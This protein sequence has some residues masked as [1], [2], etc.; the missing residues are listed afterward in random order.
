MNKLVT[1]VDPGYQKSVS[2]VTLGARFCVKCLW[3][4]GHVMSLDNTLDEL[5][6]KQ[7]PSGVFG[8]SQAA[9]MVALTTKSTGTRDAG[10]LFPPRITLTKPVNAPAK[11]PVALC[12]VLLQE[13]NYIVIYKNIQ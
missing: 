10:V 1:N 3:K 5:K 12:Y 6:N 13:K 11:S 8:F 4:I 7:E 2:C 9:A